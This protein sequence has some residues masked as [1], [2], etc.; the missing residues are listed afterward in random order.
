MYLRRL[1]ALCL[2][3]IISI[4]ALAQDLSD[5]A[6]SGAEDAAASGETEMCLRALPEECREGDLGAPDCLNSFI[7]RNKTL[8]ASVEAWK[9]VLDSCKAGGG[10][11]RIAELERQL[12]EVHAERD[13]L[14]EQHQ[15]AEH[16]LERDLERAQAQA[17][18]LEERLRSQE[19]EVER[20]RLEAKDAKV[21]FERDLDRTR[22]LLDRA[23]GRIRELL[24]AG[25]IGRTDP[26]G[27][28]GPDC[29]KDASAEGCPP[30]PPPLPSSDIAALID[31]NPKLFGELSH[32]QRLKLVEE[33]ET[34]MPAAAAIRNVFRSRL[35]KRRLQEEMRG[36]L[37]SRAPLNCDEPGR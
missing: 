37:C 23:R 3:A 16:A 10:R 35:K 15:Q 4:P 17:E 29:E 25:P 9:Q 2:A 20:E 28:A 36:Y 22:R 6:E 32:I 13:A 8:A 33:L 21:E 7:I 27:V 31:A 11:E 26:I 19:D 34:G 18:T 24:N 5:A 14:T 1:L 30:P 12:R